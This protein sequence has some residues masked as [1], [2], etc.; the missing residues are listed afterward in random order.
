MMMNMN[1]LFTEYKNINK[2]I[3]TLIKN[4]NEESKLAK[5]P[6]ELV[7]IDTF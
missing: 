3:M 6:K 1:E 7:E 5:P 2:K 4:W